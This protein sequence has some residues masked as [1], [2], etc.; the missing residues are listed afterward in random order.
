M[1][2]ILNA[3]IWL[4]CQPI[5]FRKQLDGLII[6]IA[7]TLKK[8]P[9]SGH[10]FVFRNKQANKIK[11]IVWERNGFWMLYKRI[12]KGRFQFPEKKEKDL[13]LTTAQLSWLLSG[14]SIHQETSITSLTPTSFY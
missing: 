5:D 8:N 3:T 4:Y 10:W 12:E 14:I 7:S 11:I 9:A 13:Q 2:T 6:E 1:L